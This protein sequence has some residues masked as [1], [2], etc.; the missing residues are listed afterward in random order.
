MIPSD[1]GQVP[2]RLEVQLLMMAVKVIITIAIKNNFFI[3]F[4]WG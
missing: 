2:L 1:I 4:F 3:V